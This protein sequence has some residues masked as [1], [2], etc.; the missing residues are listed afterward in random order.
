MY[1]LCIIGYGISGICCSKVAKDNNLNFLVFESSNSFGGSWYNKAFNWTKIQTHINYYQFPDFR[2]KPRKRKKSKLEQDYPCKKEILEYLNDYINVNNLNSY[3]RYNHKILKTI[4]R[5]N[6]WYII[7]KNN[8]TI[9]YVKSKYLSV[10]SGLLAEKNIPNINNI[11]KFNGNVFHSSDLLNQYFIDNNKLFYSNKKAKKILII[12]NGASCSDILQGLDRNHEIIVLYRNPKWYVKRYILGVSI[13]IIISDLV[14]KISKI[15][16]KSIYCI[17]FSIISKLIFNNYLPLPNQKVNYKNL[18][19][20]DYVNTYKNVKYV[21]GFIK[22]INE[23]IILIEN[24]KKRI[25]YNCDIIIYAT[26]YN[27]NIPF[28]NINTSLKNYKHIINPKI[29]KC[30]FIGF[31]PSYN[32]IQVSYYQSKWFIENIVKSKPINKTIMKEYIQNESLR[33]QSNNLEYND[34]TYDSFSYINMLKN[35]LN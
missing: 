17:L 23:N 18:I 21:N 10:C 30:G 3:V 22:S 7:Y 35:T 9:N 29:E 28:M 15:I 24:D 12:G 31:C 2:F 5:N 16:P 33:Q 32:W 19:A 25:S 13:S 11:E 6:Y 1:D 4:Y 34:L 26:G 14:L 8:K 20:D 27:F